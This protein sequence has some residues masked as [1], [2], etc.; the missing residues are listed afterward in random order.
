MRSYVKSIGLPALV[1]AL[2]LG[3][4]AFANRSFSAAEPAPAFE[5]RPILAEPLEHSAEQSAADVG[6]ARGSDD[7]PITVIEFSD[8]GCPYCG[9]F[10]LETYPQLEREFIETGKVRWVYVPFVMGMFPNGEEATRAAEC[11][12]DQ[13]E[14]AFWA[15]HDALYKRQP[16]WK[17]SREPGELFQSLA[18]TIEL[19]EA[20]FSACYTEDRPAGRINTSNALARQNGV[21]ATPTFFVNGKRVQGALPIE[22]FRTILTSEGW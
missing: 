2:G 4:I 22:H 1:I 16:E 21:N 18:A 20:E 19:D 17:F 7:A 14:D 11:A 3:G 13:G 6:Y 15:M 10:A 9:Q 8:F 5:P 12:A